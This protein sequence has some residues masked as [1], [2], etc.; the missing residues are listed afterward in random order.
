MPWV[1]RYRHPSMGTRS[2]AHVAI[3]CVATAALVACGGGG[4]GSGAS[5]TVTVSGLPD[6]VAA[7]VRVTGDGRSWELVGTQTLRVTPGAFEVAAGPV[8]RSTRAIAP[9]EAYAPERA[10]QTVDVAGTANVGVAYQHESP[11]L[12]LVPTFGF[13]LRGLDVGDLAAGAHATWRLAES[14]SASV[15][16]VTGIAVG[17]DERVYLADF[18]G[19]RIVVATLDATPRQVSLTLDGALRTGAGSS[20]PLTAPVGLAFD[21]AGG[22]WVGVA[23]S[24]A[25]AAR[26]LRFDS[27]DVAGIQGDAERSPSLVID[28]VS[29]ADTGGRPWLFDLFV[30]HADRLWLADSAD[31]RVLRF[32]DPAGSGGGDVIPDLELRSASLAGRA[33]LQ[34]PTSLVVDAADRLYVGTAT[35]VAR[36]DDAGALES[37]DTLPNALIDTENG[38]SHDL[39]AL[40]GSGALWIAH[41]DG[42]LARVLEPHTGSGLLRVRADLDRSLRWSAQGEEPPPDV[43]G[44]NLTFA[45]PAPAA[46]IA[47]RP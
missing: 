17:S 7:D 37:G 26:L 16:T 9:D 8:T 20:T 44:G 11:A 36:Y 33:T 42:E 3:A 34:R 6:G 1:G 14:G 2:L 12:L 29:G 4:G 39:V 23:G 25:G 19:D 32:D 18:E 30:D 31:D 45:L 40:D 38:T 22:L 5:L 41:F 43:I 27:E 46:A 21:A 24:A 35:H 28:V 13:G 47:D 15:A 10:T